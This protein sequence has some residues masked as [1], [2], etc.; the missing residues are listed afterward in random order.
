MALA[1]CG[2]EVSIISEGW[3]WGLRQL[4]A[5]KT[6]QKARILSALPVPTALG[7]C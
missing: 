5:G 7:F 4:R 6:Y 1:L 2:K 3:K